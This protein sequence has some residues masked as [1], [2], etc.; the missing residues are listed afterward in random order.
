MQIGLGEQLAVG[1]TFVVLITALIGIRTFLRDSALKRAEWLERLHEKFYVRENYKYIRRVLD[2]ASPDQF[3]AFKTAINSDTFTSEQEMLVDYL[4]F[5]H[6]IGAIWK[7]GQL[8][9]REIKLL[10][11]YYLSVLAKH[12]FLLD[13]MRREKF[14]NLLTMLK[15]F[16][17][18]DRKKPA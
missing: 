1:Q 9:E 3:A 15:K 16:G 12:D 10:F 7:R 8:N 13:Y 2:Y 11:S 14:Y 6:F 5:F 4:N 17:Y 18:L